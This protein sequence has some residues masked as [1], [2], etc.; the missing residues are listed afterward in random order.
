MVFAGRRRWLHAAT[1]FTLALVLVAV[2]ACG[3]TDSAAGRKAMDAITGQ[4]QAAISQEPNVL[5]AEVNYQDTLDAAGTV[6][7]GIGIKSGVEAQP[8][9]DD[10]VRRIWQSSLNPI[11]SI[12]IDIG[13]ASNDEQGISQ[14]IDAIGQ[15]AR[16]D[17]QYGPH[18]TK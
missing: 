1:S 17:S 3:R 4:I 18:P 7:V 6:A 12:R 10:A 16:L 15:K 14:T 11:Y 13:Y 9:F 5:S 2:P 8:F